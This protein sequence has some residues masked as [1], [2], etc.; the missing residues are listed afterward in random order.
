MNLSFY[1]KNLCY[2][3][4]FYI[5]LVVFVWLGNELTSF[6]LFIVSL[7][8]F[9][10]ALMYPFVFLF[11]VRRVRFLTTTFNFVNWGAEICLLLSLPPIGI[12]FM[13]CFFINRQKTYGV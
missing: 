1:F 11:F 3:A 12:V 10:G 7:F 4:F 2:S 9:F 6:W 13:I 5:L 8:F